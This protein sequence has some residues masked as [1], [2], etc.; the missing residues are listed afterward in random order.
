MKLEF[1]VTGMTCAACS[2]RVEKVTSAVAGVEKAEVNLLAGKMTVYASSDVHE[3]IEKAVVDAG[4][5]IANPEAKKQSLP[6]E[7]HGLKEMKQRIIGSASCLVLLMYFTMGH[8]VGLPLPEWYH[9]NVLTAALL[10][11]FLTLPVV[12]LNRA[13]YFRGIKALYHRAPNMD[14]L[15]AVGSLAAL[16]YGVAT[17]FLMADAMGRGDVQALTAYGHNLYFES[18][19][20]ILSLVSLGKYLEHISKKKTTKS[21]KKKSK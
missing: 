18:A 5:G 14:S 21:S 9:H 8:M 17:L 3:A 12:Y 15:I 20:M 4:Y 10:Q 1:R 16:I 19:G 2:A 13:Y 6:Q 11:F 7:D